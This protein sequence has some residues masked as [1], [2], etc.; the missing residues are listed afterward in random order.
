MQVVSLHIVGEEVYEFIR[1][2][3]GKDVT[4]ES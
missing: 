1:D 2:S 4:L 3:G